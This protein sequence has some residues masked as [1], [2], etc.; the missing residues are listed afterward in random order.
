MTNP[1]S[2]IW[3]EAQNVGRRVIKLAGEEQHQ[4]LILLI[5]YCRNLVSGGAETLMNWVGIKY[6][7]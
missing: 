4:N 6:S 7:T 1:I 3:G 5:K 2:E